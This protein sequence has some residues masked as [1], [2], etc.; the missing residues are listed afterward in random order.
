MLFTYTLNKES[1]NPA[2]ELR[3]ENNQVFLYQPHH[4]ESVNFE[5]FSND[6]EAI[7]WA[8]NWLATEGPIWEQAR[9]AP[10]VEKPAE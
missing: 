1:Q 8:E 4:H 3:D 2:V 7:A 10:P 9:L 5:P 6:E